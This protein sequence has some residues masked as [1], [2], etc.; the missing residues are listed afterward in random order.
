LRIDGLAPVLQ[1]ALLAALPKGGDAFRSPTPV[2]EASVPQA[3]AVTIPGP[4]TSVQMLVALAT[5]EPVI[6][7]RRKVTERAEKGLALLE[8]VHAA[9]AI[10]PPPD[11][12]QL[13]DLI[14]WSESFETPDDP[15]LAELAREIELRVRVEIAKLELRI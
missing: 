11:R 9:L 13:Q 4:A 15:A 10:G 3:P 2:P 5:P 8:R 6:D 12:E 14:D 7:R 1:Q